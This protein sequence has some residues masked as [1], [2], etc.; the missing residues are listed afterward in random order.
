MKPIDHKNG[1]S[2]AA[3]PTR[4]EAIGFVSPRP[5]FDTATTPKK[6]PEIAVR[7]LPLGGVIHVPGGRLA[8]TM[9]L[10]ISSGPRG[11]TS[12][13]ASVYRWARRTGGYIWELR[14]RGIQIATLMETVS[15]G[16]RVGR[17]ILD[18]EIEVVRDEAMGAAN[19][20]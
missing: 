5:D 11:F 18:C 6:K 7:V 17:Y 10:L 13:E 15:D 2:G 19:D 14:K 12:G 9:R 1:P 8:E 4:A 3:T 20:G 16:A